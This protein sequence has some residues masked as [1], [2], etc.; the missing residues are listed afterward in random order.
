MTRPSNRLP[1]DARH[2]FGGAEL[3]RSRPLSFRLNG[4]SIEGFA[5]DTVLSALLANGFEAAG[6]RHGEAIGLDERFNPLVVPRSGDA[7]RAMPMDRVPALP[8]LDLMTVGTRRENFGSRGLLGRAIGLFSRRMHTLGHRFDDPAPPPWLSAEP[9]ATIQTGTLVIGGGLAGMSAALGVTGEPVI[10]AERRP[11]LGGNARFFG[12]VGDEEAPDSAITRLT[13]SLAKRPAIQVLTHTDVF[14]LSGTTARAHQVQVVDGKLTS[15]VVLI[16]AQHVVIATG[17]MERL[18]LFAGNRAPGVVGA[19]TAFHRADRYGVWIGKRALFNTPHSFG[20]RLALHA[21]DAG[22]TVQRIAD[23]RLRPQSRFIDFAKATGVTLASGLVPRAAVHLAKGATGLAVSFVV[24]I[25]EIR[26]ATETIE[27]DQFIAAGSWQ[28]EL[29]LWLQAGG[30]AVWNREAGW[31]EGQSPP[32]N[33]ALAGSAAGYRSLSACLASGVA[34]VARL[35]GKNAPPVDDPR[36]EEIYESADAL[37]PVAPWSDTAHSH[38]FLDG[39]TSFALRPDP[40]NRN[41]RLAVLARS[42]G[43]GDIAAGVDIGDIP[44]ADAGAVAS[45]RCIS[46]DDIVP[47][48]W[49]PSAAKR[50]EGVPPYLAGRFGDKAQLHVLAAPDAR[51]FETGAMVFASSDATDPLAAVGAIIGPAP[52][53]KPGGVALLGRQ[54]LGLRVFVRDAGG[55]VAVDLIEKLPG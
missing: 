19:V 30:E 49:R 35:L 33:V 24:A 55:A 23:T 18:P 28:P 20:Y 5:G 13:A 38:S 29:T 43:L 12:A 51:F 16:E 7:R 44:E 40:E 22:I 46:G 48:S 34:A 15:R 17:A 50:P 14:A 21:N 10:L 9:D 31:L 3:D 52:G 53:G 4:R 2:N 37:T 45:E 6:T 32:P 36:I 8:G 41:T 1:A 25:D 47:N 26:Q 27:T 39:G 42:L 54:A 11:M